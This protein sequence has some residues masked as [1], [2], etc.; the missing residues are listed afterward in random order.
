MQ[1]VLMVTL[2]V[3]MLYYLHG[4]VVHANHTLLFT[5]LL[6]IYLRNLRTCK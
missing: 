5:I 1:M 4:E 6:L 2:K 3:Y